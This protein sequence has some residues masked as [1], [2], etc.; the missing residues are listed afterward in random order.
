MSEAWIILYGIA[1]CL[2]VLGL[3]IVARQ[4]KHT[5]PTQEKK[6]ESN[7]GISESTGAGDLN[8]KVFK[9]F[10]GSPSGLDDEIKA[11]R[12]EITAYNDL[13]AN[14]R[15]HH[16]DV[17]RWEDIPSEYG[18]RPQAIINE[19]LVQCHAYVLLL[20]DRWGT[21]PGNST[22]TSGCEEEFDEAENCW[23]SPN[24]PMKKIAIYFKQIDQNKPRSLGEQQ[25]L[26]KVIEFK[27][28]L[29]DKRKG[30]FNEF[31]DISGMRHLV[32]SFLARWLQEATG[33]RIPMGVQN[34]LDYEKRF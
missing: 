28:F 21:P 24:K 25:Q 30:L 19:E 9:I 32:R 10:L 1:L 6:V 2:L 13:E 3:L 31:G 18:R 7:E 16:F 15:K 17:S 14:P 27:Q 34:V 8:W 26:D 20:W 11:L 29:M 33:I 4:W 12:K 5:N 23:G 22:N